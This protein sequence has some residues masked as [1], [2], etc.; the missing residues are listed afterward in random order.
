MSEHFAYQGLHA[1]AAV[2]GAGRIWLAEAHDRQDR[3]DR[4]REE[5]EASNGGGQRDDDEKCAHGSRGY[6]PRSTPCSLAGREEWTG[7][8]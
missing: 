1:L 4:L 5:G 3:T 2:I 8:E 7:R 6:P